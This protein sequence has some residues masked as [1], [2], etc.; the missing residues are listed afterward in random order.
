M[1]RNTLRGVYGYHKSHLET[2]MQ[3]VRS[4]RL[5]VRGSISVRLPVT[6]AAE[7]VRILS[8]KRNDP[9]RVVLISSDSS[10]T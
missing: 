9:V 5:D 3:L 8:E 7:G 2:L 10:G 1:L 6:E 4:G